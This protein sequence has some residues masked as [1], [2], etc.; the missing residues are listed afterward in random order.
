VSAERRDGPGDAGWNRASITLTG[1]LFVYMTAEMFPVGIVP[2]LAPGL[3]CS[4]AAAGTL[5]AVYAIAA[6]VAIIPVVA[7]TRR[8]DRRRLIVA[9]LL[10]LAVSQVAFALSD[11]LW[12]AYA[13]RAV[14][15]VPH[16]LLWSVVP[17]VAAS[18][19]PGAPG[20]ATAR[21][22]VGGAL[23]LVVG[24]PL[25]T[26]TTG[27]VG[28][29]PTAMAVGVMAVV[30]AV[31]ARATLPAAE[32][33]PHVGSSGSRG[34]RARRL[35]TIPAQV[36]GLSTA[37]VAVVAACYIPYTYL[38]LL[39]DDVGIRSTSLSAL[40]IGYGA[41]GLVT[42]SLVGRFLDHRL[43]AVLC[44]ILGGMAVAMVMITTGGAALFILA[45]LLWGA[46]F[47]CAAPALQSAVLRA[48]HADPRVDPLAASAVY[49]LA[50]QVGIAGGSWAGSGILSRIGEA[51]LAPAGL[52]AVAASAM[53]V[54]ALRSP[55]TV[56]D[57]A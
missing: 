31:A 43:R 49:V 57:T 52:I 45:V 23:G 35:P 16:G 42:V 38:S 29:R 27:L 44:A 17:T 22:F 28:W 19:S 36:F 33:G 37:T 46:A 20:R 25:V 9:S 12:W 4:Q 48:S 39:A 47:A 34:P 5:L 24:A 32:T 1:A 11:N 14:A 41:A 21:V 54:L 26:A 8:L 30:L 18:M 53:V 55:T 40:Q 2:E 10:V 15:A 7:L 13:A 3:R 56:T 51:W 6:G 50:F